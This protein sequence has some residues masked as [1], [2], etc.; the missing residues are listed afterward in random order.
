MNPL[1]TQALKGFL[2]LLGLSLIA[3]V[4]AFATEQIHPPAVQSQAD[5]EFISRDH[6]VTHRSTLLSNLN[7][8][9][10]IFVR[11]KVLHRYANSKRPVVL[12]VH[13]ATVPSVPDFDLNFEDY[14]WMAY[15]ARRGFRVYA[16]DLSGYGVSPRPLMDDPCQVAPQ[17]RESLNQEVASVVCNNHSG[18]EFNTIHDDWAEIDTVVDHLRRTNRLKTIDMV[19]WSAGGPR[20]GGYLAKYPEKVARAM[21][22]APSPTLNKDPQKQAPLGHAVSL[23]S[24]EDFE[25][26]RWDPDVRCSNQVTQKA[27]DAVW[28][29]VMKWDSTGAVWGPKDVGVMRGRIASQFNWTPDM[30]QKVVTPTLVVVGEFDRLAE[31]KSVYDQISSK[32]KVFVGVDC[33]SHF[34][35][36]EKQ[37]HILHQ[38][39]YEWFGKGTIQGRSDGVFNVDEAQQFRL[40]R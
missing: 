7:Q 37:R 3:Q 18:H 1:C 19:G 9:V 39:S 6:F 40:I 34:M 16:M 35:L 26:K 21:L 4:Q 10:G 31:R 36:W 33:A 24:R 38:T 14:N 23:Q 25:L 32:Q 17:Y 5:Q 13:G 27:R 22:Y 20:V 2:F 28:S 29:E 8:P 15:L 12:F 11:E 30:A